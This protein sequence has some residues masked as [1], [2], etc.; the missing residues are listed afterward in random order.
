MIEIVAASP[1]DAD[2]IF[3]F[4]RI[5]DEITLTVKCF[6]IIILRNIFV[7]PFAFGGKKIRRKV[8]KKI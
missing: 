6:H 2:K 4:Y 7:F 5:Y 1:E 3:R 8:C